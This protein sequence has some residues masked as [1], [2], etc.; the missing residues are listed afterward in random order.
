ML[1]LECPDSLTSRK[2]DCPFPRLSETFAGFDSFSL[3]FMLSCNYQK[4]FFV[5]FS[6][7]QLSLISG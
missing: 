3:E 7:V 1:M 4:S 5:Q 2:S 6:L